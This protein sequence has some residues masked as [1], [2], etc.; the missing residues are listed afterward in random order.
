MHDPKAFWKTI[1]KI[2]PGESKEYHRASKL[3]VKSA[4]IISR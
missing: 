1:K 2:M 3:T 4:L